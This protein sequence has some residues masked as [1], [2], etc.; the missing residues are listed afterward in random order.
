MKVIVEV[1]ALE[2]KAY[3][4]ELLTQIAKEVI[5][6]SGI[7]NY[8]NKKITLSVAMVNEDEMRRVNKKLRGKD[9]VTNVL[10]IGDYSDEKDIIQE[11]QNE[12]FLGEVILCY[13]YIQQIARENGDN[14]DKEFFTIYAHGVLHL[15]G[16]VHGENM[17]H[18]QDVIGDKF[19]I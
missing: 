7:K 6:M 17:F 1:Y 11:S 19:V 2:K 16:F 10:S 15:L 8:D 14:V 9:A 12:I 5:E 18:L 3:D 13:N 4:K